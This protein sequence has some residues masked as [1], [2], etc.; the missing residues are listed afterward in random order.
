MAASDNG[1]GETESSLP[2]TALL[3]AEG[4]NVDPPATCGSMLRILLIGSEVSEGCRRR[5]CG[6]M[7]GDCLTLRD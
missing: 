7:A 5:V 4:C 1:S 6:F 2:S 3:G